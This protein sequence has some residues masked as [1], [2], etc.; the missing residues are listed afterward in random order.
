[1]FVCVL[2][3]DWRAERKEIEN[4]SYLKGGNLRRNELLEVNESW[5]SGRIVEEMVN[6]KSEVRRRSVRRMET[7]LTGLLQ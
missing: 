6:G 1:V 7:I 5:K 3:I 4:N 2:C